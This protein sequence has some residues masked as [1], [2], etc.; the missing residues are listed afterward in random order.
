MI[1]KCLFQYI[2]LTPAA[3]ERH[4]PPRSRATTPRPAHTA[5]QGDIGE[6]SGANAQLGESGGRGKEPSRGWACSVPTMVWHHKIMELP[7]RTQP[8]LHVLLLLYC[9]T[10]WV[11]GWDTLIRVYQVSTAAAASKRLKHSAELR[12]RPLLC[13][14]YVLLLCCWTRRVGG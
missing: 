3:A 5:A 4:R 12:T 10:W 9:C 7:A 1:S 11:V 13:V 8:L 2:F 6:R 14:P